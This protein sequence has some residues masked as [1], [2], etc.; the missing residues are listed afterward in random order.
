MRFE[1]ERLSGFFRRSLVALGARLGEQATGD[2][3]EA[4]VGAPV[5]AAAIERLQDEELADGGVS[6]ET[7]LRRA[8]Q[9]LML[10]LIERD[11]RGAASLDEVCRAMTSFA[12]QATGR[13]MR[14][15]AATLAERHGRPLDREGRPQ[16]LLAVGM[17]KAGGDEL[18]VSSDL[19]LVFVFR[20]EGETEGVDGVGRI[21][22]SDWMHR[23]ARRTISVLSEITAD[24]FVF[25]VD[26]RLRPN[27]DSGPLVVPLGM[28][29]TYFYAQG[30]E[31]E[32]FAWLKGRV[33]ADSG[34]AGAEARRA[35]ELSLQRIV[36]PFVFRRYMDY[37]AFAALRDLHRL[38]RQEVAKRGARDPEAIDVKLGRGGIREIE[39]TAQL[40]Q[41]VRGGRD[42]GLRDRRT[43]V[44]LAALAER[45]LLPADDAARL[46]RAYRLLRRTEHAI[47]YRED[48]QT[49]R[50]PNDPAVRAEVAAMLRLAPA[51]FD[52]AIA[53]A[54][55]AVEA[56]F[57]RLLTP[58]TAPAKESAPAA[59]A[60]GELDPEVARRFEGLRAGPRY[61][62]AKA[63]TREAIE[64]LLADAVR[65]RTGSA[66]LVRLVDLL[67]TVCRRPAYVALLAQFPEA[68][69]RVLRILDWSKWPAEYLMRHPVVLDEL[70]DGEL[71]EPTDYD[72][73]AAELARR[74]DAALIDGQP[75]VERQMDIVREAHHAQVFRLMVQDLEGR[76]TVE[77]VSD[78]LSDLADRVLDLAIRIVWSQLRHRFR[79][80]PRFAAIAYGRLGGKELGYAS[81]LDLVFLFDDDDER[82]PEA[83]AVLA[84]RLAGWLSTRTA[85]GLLFEIDLRLR[86]NGAAGLLVSTLSAFEAYQ[87]ESAWPWEHQAL[88]RARFC[89]GDRAIGERFEAIRREVLARRRD[90]ARLGE[91]VVA[92]RRK[93]HD[94][95]PNR[96]ELF[97]IKHD[98][99]GMVDIEFI[100]QFLVLAHSAD[101]PELQA[102][103]G[104]IALL[105]M[106]A[107]AG[108]IEPALAGKVADAYR[109]YRRLQHKLR[110]DDAE[111]ARIPPEEAKDEREAVTRLWQTVLGADQRPA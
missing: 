49:H 81:D 97:D 28:L 101:H 63:T 61:A 7:G 42:P 57:D 107:D 9:W 104:N 88:T 77:T 64:R 55:D 15:A 67:E 95:H 69:Q 39:F 41:V 96:S 31:W 21:P 54:T 111:Y 50:L 99:G 48:A 10:A 103:R 62:A 26:T 25:R 109:R 65:L 92:M 73:W 37:E 8:R 32:R 84:Q 80:T 16:D 5:D 4:L 87:R 53:E 40:F 17:G 20:D 27:G 72:E 1:A 108:L 12:G 89:A 94:G 45:G 6:I 24:G 43:L 82:A 76:L 2:R 3:L 22:S 102:N 93:M 23:L 33:I 51:D 44:T 74:V 70:L 14:D 47:Q 79:D 75:D 56:I 52:A 86:P 91:E 90:L 100:V 60:T 35:D 71:L 85:A 66:G 58:T 83:Y 59:G 98:R 78:H 68:F 18:N 46:D 30:R 29:E 110:L 105:G 106:A 13:A 36:E 34:A 11:V 38:I 19:D